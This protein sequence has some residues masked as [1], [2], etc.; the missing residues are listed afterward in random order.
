ML[1][2]RSVLRGAASAGA[3]LTVAACTPAIQSTQATSAATVIKPRRGG[4]MKVPDS[5]YGHLD[6][7]LELVNSYPLTAVYEGL[8]EY[9]ANDYNDFALAPRLAEKWSVSADGLTVTLNL[10]KGVKWH[11]LPPVNGR[12][13][14]SADVAWNAQYYAKSSGFPYLWSSVS[15]VETPDPS[16]VVIRLKQASASFVAGLAHR[17]NQ[18]YPRELFEADGNFKKRA[19][20]TGPFLVTDYVPTERLILV[21]NPAYWDVSEVDGQPLPYMDGLESYVAKDELS[22]LAGLRTGKFDM[23]QAASGTTLDDVRDFPGLGIQL[24]PGVAA[25]MR[26]LLIGPNGPNKEKMRDKRVRQA[27][28][29]AVNR[30]GWIDVI[31]GKDQGVYQDWVA[32]QGWAWTQD[33][34][35]AKFRYDPARA[36][37]LLADAGATG[38]TVKITSLS[39]A[40]SGLN[41]KSADFIAN[42]LKAVGFKTELDLFPDVTALRTSRINPGTYDIMVY[43]QASFGADPSDYLNGLLSTT[44]VTVN[45]GQVKDTA[46]DK[47]IIDQDRAVDPKQRKAIIDQIQDYL[48]DQMYLV[49]LAQ[50]KLVKPLAARVKGPNPIHASQKS[51]HVERVWLE[52]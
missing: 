28:S 26:D 19:I 8:L 52:K 39:D 3:I 1:T 22:R 43:V 11:N 36:K 45:Y 17:N 23:N 18:M 27:I 6:N 42:D 34:M 38:L 16:T 21:K 40:S 48:F 46:L 33:Q 37:Q 13:F 44:P 47:L 32:V 15:S 35:K 7:S 29:L 9:R 41:A 50:P 10:R 25:F 31:Y 51:V 5:G 2:R 20:G 49:P 14:T 30:D 4:V 24:V 12:E